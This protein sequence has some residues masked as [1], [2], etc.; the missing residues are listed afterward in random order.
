MNLFGCHALALYRQAGISFASETTNY[1][2]CFARIT[3][4]MDLGSCF[5]SVRFESFEITIEMKQ[6][7]VFDGACLRAQLFPVRETSGCFTPALSKKRR[8]F[9]QRPAQLHVGER[10]TRVGVECLCG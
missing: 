7:F 10:G 5:F 1:R 8:C 9:A 4:P 3:R 6:G 2:V